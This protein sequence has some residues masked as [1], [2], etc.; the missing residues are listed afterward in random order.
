MS[1]EL[2]KLTLNNEIVLMRHDVRKAKVHLVHKITRTIETLRN[3]KGP[4]KPTEKDLLKADKLVEEIRTLKKLKDDLIT[5][6]LLVYVDDPHK[7]LSDVSQ[8]WER[9]Q[10][11]TEKDLLK[12][13]KLVE[14][15]RTLKKLK[16][17]LITKTLLVYVDDPHKVLSDVNKS[18][19]DRIMAKMFTHKSM[20]ASISKFREKYPNWLEEVTALLKTMKKKKP[21]V[22]KEKDA[23]K[24]TAVGEK[25]ENNNGKV[26]RSKDSVN[27]LENKVEKSVRTTV[28]STSGSWAVS[29]SVQVI[30]ELE[31]DDVTKS[32]KV[33]KKL[34]GKSAKVTPNRGEDTKHR[35]IT[36]D[37]EK[38]GEENGEGLLFHSSG[39]DLGGQEN[40]FEKERKVDKRRCEEGEKLMSGGKK[41]KKRKIEK[42]EGED[43]EGNLE[44][45]FK[46]EKETGKRIDNGEVDGGNLEDRF[47]KGKKFDE[48]DVSL[49][50]RFEKPEVDDREN[51]LDE[52]LEERFGRRKKTEKKVMDKK[53]EEMKVVDPF[54][55]TNDN[56]EYLTVVSSKEQADALQNP[57]KTSNHYKND[58]EL[59][60]GSSLTGGFKQVSHHERRQSS[61][62]N[63]GGR[64]SGGFHD[65]KQNGGFREFGK[66]GGRNEGGFGKNREGFGMSSS[67][68]S[69]FSLPRRERRKLMNE[70]GKETKAVGEEKLHPS[71]EA[72]RRQSCPAIPTFSG[73]KIK[74]DD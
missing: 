62:T 20:A 72:K 69:S 54:F 21:M 17:D 50:S 11:P 71:W 1:S 14:E 9:T 7:V 51:G 36:S 12:A 48:I 5:K 65:R 30:S 66:G 31:N 22:K 35:I 29:G 57:S 18:L 28:S 70:G 27:K 58:E 63:L 67:S 19:Q 4:K 25:S 8:K 61:F 44:D 10:K 38:F 39:M 32:E 37:N 60:Y 49:K 68:T 73:K 56:S 43:S 13:D 64:S 23:K 3:G 40:G 34:G 74:F 33:S 52:D 55:M 24:N 15:I 26:V 53:K 47:K 41:K 46:I 45:M 16:D 42:L 6:T 2:N 59:Y